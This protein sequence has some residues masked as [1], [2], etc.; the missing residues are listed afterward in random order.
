MT[1]APRPPYGH[2]QSLLTLCACGDGYVSS[3]L[4]DGTA[5]CA[6]CARRS[7]E[8]EQDNGN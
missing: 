7:I 5:A 8:K 3:R 1:T 2:A 6:V 4:D